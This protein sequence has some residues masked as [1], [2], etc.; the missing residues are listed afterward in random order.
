VSLKV[1]VINFPQTFGAQPRF[2]GGLVWEERARVVLRDSPDSVLAWA[3]L[4]PLF[5]QLFLPFELRGRL[6]GM[7]S[8]EDQLNAWASVDELLASLEIDLADELAI[9]RYG[10]GWSRLRSAEQL[11]AK[12]RLLA[13][14]ASHA[15][16]ELA[17]CYRVHRLLP[18][19]ARYYNKA[20]DG[21]ARRQQV[22]TRPLERTLSGFF[23]GDWLAF[24]DYLG[25]KPHQ[26][27]EIALAIPETR[28]LTGGT[29]TAATIA[30]EKGLPAAEV[31][32]M[33]ATFWETSAVRAP[34]MN[35]PM[36]ERVAVL[37]DFWRPF[38]DLHA[39]QAS[40]MP[41]LWGLVED[42]REIRIGWDAPDWYHARQYEELLP[43]KLNRAIER[44]WGSIM[45]PRWP[46]RLVSEIAPHALM[47]EAFGAALD[48]WH[49]C[50]LTAWFV[51]EGPMSRTDLAGLAI[52]HRDALEALQ[53]LGCPIDHALFAELQDA[54]MHL[55]PPKPI[56]E[57][58]S[59]HAVVPGISIELSTSIGTR[60][61]GFERLRD[62]VSRH[63]R[64]WA[65]Q[66][67]GNYLHTRWETELREAARLHAEDIAER[68]KPPSAKQFARHAATVVNHWFAGD[69]G[70]FYAAIGEKASIHTQ[71]VTLMPQDPHAFALA[72]FQSL[73]GRPFHRE[74]VVGNLAEGRAQAEEQDR[75]TKVGWLAG[76]SLNLLQLGEA[77]G[78]QP[79]MKESGAPSFEYRS[80][81]LATDVEAAWHRYTAVVE[82]VRNET[83]HAGHAEVARLP[84]APLDGSVDGPVKQ[85][86][87][88]IRPDAEPADVSD[89]HSWLRWLRRC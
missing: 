7:R 56:T 5:E 87:V 54:E 31:E 68:G 20:K 18:L 41:S 19:I 82:T 72:V 10:G 69:L 16:P 48:F 64:A 3:V 86:S 80:A 42:S 23:G 25:E 34:G 73:G 36:A 81:V 60:R 53:R 77:L 70:G 6:V 67:L 85:A 63:R 76:Q 43:A 2:A 33:L 35:S 37:E 24:L 39:R 50:A 27:E 45:L 12:K 11:E 32:R 30:A 88:P 14:L 8:R 17:S 1:G 4:E 15:T 75:S 26:D 46:D 78:R 65:E 40:G 38:D 84:A 13:G 89:Q 44:L 83:R 57:N 52:Y 47:A 58:R 9:M 29:K 62:I 59:T 71:R 21:R 55:G 51:C 66:Y 74:A 22:L 61:S 79:T 28:L 49:G